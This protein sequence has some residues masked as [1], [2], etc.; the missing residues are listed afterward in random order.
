MPCLHGAVFF[1]FFH[2]ALTPFSYVMI[3]VSV[4][5]LSTLFT[6]GMFPMS[7]KEIHTFLDFLIITAFHHGCNIHQ[8]LLSGAFLIVGCRL[9]PTLFVILKVKFKRSCDSCDTSIDFNSLE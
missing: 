7:K 3:L 4:E 9:E 6:L 5:S 1:F 8:T 2:P